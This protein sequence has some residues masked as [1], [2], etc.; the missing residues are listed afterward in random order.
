MY[1]T[2]SGNYEKNIY[3]YIFLDKSIY[4]S[5]PK[6]YSIIFDGIVTRDTG[7]STNMQLSIVL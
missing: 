6:I 1:K 5:Q 2:F 3:K 7:Y 4:S